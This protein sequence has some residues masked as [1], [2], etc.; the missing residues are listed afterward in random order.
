MGSH[1][2]CNLR[3]IPHVE[4]NIQIDQ[5]L[6]RRRF[7]LS[8]AELKNKSEAEQVSRTTKT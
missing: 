8:H 4:I 1:S 2:A 3:S 5:W 6:T 7:I